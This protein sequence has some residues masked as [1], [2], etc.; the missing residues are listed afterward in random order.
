MSREV[1]DH[2]REAAGLLE[3][4]G[5]CQGTMYHEGKSCAI[6]A[7]VRSAKTNELI[8]PAYQAFGFHIGGN[9]VSWNDRPGRTQAEVVKA[10]LG[11]A[12]AQE[13]L[14]DDP[15]STS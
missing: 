6:G 7:I 11:A 9:I 1:A 10:F 12:E 13:F 5:W 3:T 8:H 4:H 14:G 15:D 2:F